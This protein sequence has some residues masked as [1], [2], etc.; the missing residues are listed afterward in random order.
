MVLDSTDFKNIEFASIIQA[1][2]PH[3]EE[4]AQAQ[5][6]S[7]LRSFGIFDHPDV[8]A[9][10]D[11]DAMVKATLVQWVYMQVSSDNFNPSA[12]QTF[13]GDSSLENPMNVSYEQAER[14]FRKLFENITPDSLLKRNVRSAGVVGTRFRG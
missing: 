4:L 12:L 1:E 2:T 6:E 14:Q 10:A 13:D 11:V 3:Y 9:D 8:P 5:Y 7:W